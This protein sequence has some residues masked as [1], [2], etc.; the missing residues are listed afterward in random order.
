MKALKIVGEWVIWEK[1]AI[2]NTFT[3]NSHLLILSR[4]V[5]S[6]GS[7][8]WPC[9]IKNFHVST[10]YSATTLWVQNS[11]KNRSISD[12]FR[13]ICLFH[14]PQKFKMAAKTCK[15]WNILY[16]NRILLYYPAGQKFTRNCSISY[17]FRDICTFCIL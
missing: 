7:E 17:S 1:L 16:C 8:T 9:E 2:Y 13:D 10:E 5:I 15:I 4:W 11:L 3:D 12:S 14:F 6:Y